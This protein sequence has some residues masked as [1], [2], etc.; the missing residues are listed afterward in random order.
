MRHVDGNST[1][2]TNATAANRPDDEIVLRYL[3]LRT[4]QGEELDSAAEFEGA[5]AFV[6]DYGYQMM[7]HG[8]FLPQ[9]GT[10]A[11]AAAISGGT[12]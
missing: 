3:K 12:G 2:G 10:S 7:I 9:G 1:R 4:L 5:K 6:G 11:T 8:R